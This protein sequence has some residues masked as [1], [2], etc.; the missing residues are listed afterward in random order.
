[1]MSAERLARFVVAVAA[2]ALLAS[3][4]DSHSGDAGSEVQLKEGGVPGEGIFAIDLA[5]RS[6]VQLASIP[7]PEDTSN[8]IKFTFEN[9]GD[10]SFDFAYVPEIEDGG[11]HYFQAFFGKNGVTSS[12]PELKL[13][14]SSTSTP[15]GPA[16]CSVRGELGF[17]AI[18]DTFVG[19]KT[20]LATDFRSLQTTTIEAAD[21]AG[22][23]TTVQSDDFQVSTDLACGNLA[24]GLVFDHL[25]RHDSVGVNDCLSFGNGNGISAIHFKDSAEATEIPLTFPNAD[26][27]ILSSPQRPPGSTLGDNGPAVLVADDGSTHLMFERLYT[28]AE[29]F[30][31]P[32]LADEFRSGG[33]NALYYK[34]IDDDPDAATEYE[35]DFSRWLARPVVHSS[36]ISSDIIVGPARPDA[37]EFVATADF[38]AP[39]ASGSDEDVFVGILRGRFDF[40]RLPPDAERRIVLD[41]AEVQGVLTFAQ[42][43]CRIWDAAGIAPTGKVYVYGVLYPRWLR[44]AVGREWVVFST[45]K[46]LLGTLEDGV[47]SF[48]NGGTE[49]VEEVRRSIC[50]TL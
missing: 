13:Q 32:N 24:S 4:S 21:A 31:D 26:P 38:K 50:G 45:V 16:Y 28:T 19:V 22:T 11:L 27:K 20:I 9:N 25:D 46:G 42:F 39:G 3:C 47:V 18:D 35:I 41:P 30:T 43:T 29:V 8:F 40:D 36:V 15:N 2:L 5:G 10:A 17:G 33:F 12:D 49:D 34:H 14:R 6:I 37:I 23:L 7:G 44:D 48:T 1:M